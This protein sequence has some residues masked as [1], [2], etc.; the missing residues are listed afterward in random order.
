V[1][2]TTAGAAGRIDLKSRRTTTSY[3]ILPVRLF[4]CTR[5]ATRTS[6]RVD[7]KG[8]R[9]RLGG[10]APRAT[11]DG[12]ADG[13]TASRSDDP[14]TRVSSTTRRPICLPSGRLSI[15]V[16]VSLSVRTDCAVVPTFKQGAIKTLS[17]LIGIWELGSFVSG[18]GQDSGVRR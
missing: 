6:S 15:P 5:E 2:L 1:S 4:A 14:A 7:R 16:P 13:D 18:R 10:E 8:L 9:R 17:L 3:R 12:Q 11:G